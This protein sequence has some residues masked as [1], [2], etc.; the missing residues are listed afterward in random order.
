[1]FCIY[2]SKD[3][4]G[5]ASGAIVKHKYPDCE[6][7]GYDY[8]ETFDFNLISKK[9]VIMTDVSMP[10][11]QMAIIANN[12]RSFTWIDHHASAIEGFTFI[13]KYAAL[14]INTRLQVGVAACELTFMHLFPGYPLPTGIELLGDYDVWRNGSKLHWDYN[15]MPFQYGMRQICISPE[16]FPVEIFQRNNYDFIDDVIVKGK[17]ILDYVKVQ[18]ERAAR[19]SFETRFEGL[20]AVCLNVGGGNS[21]MFES[22]YNEQEHDLMIPFFYSGRGW[23]FSIYTTKDIDCSALAKKYGGGGHKQAAGFKVKELPAAFILPNKES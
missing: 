16:T 10:I 9:D 12:A 4:D 1:M 23:T 6:L 14:K 7:Y 22:V 8:N 5:F 19:F 18:N 11:A 3:L 20:L 13:S 21:Q 17:N 2:H 15:V